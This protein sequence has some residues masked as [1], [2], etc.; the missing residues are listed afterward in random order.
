MI[1]LLVI[2]TEIPMDNIIAG[3]GKSIAFH[4]DLPSPVAMRS[5]P[6]EQ[7]G[8]SFQ[9]LSALCEVDWRTFNESWPLP[10]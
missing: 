8:T 10:G 7:T 6:G 3:Q 1:V 5:E 2:L 4:H 9:E